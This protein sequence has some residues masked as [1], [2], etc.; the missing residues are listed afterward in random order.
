MKAT[1][2]K[3]PKSQIEISFELTADE[4]KEHFEHALEHLKHHV[5][6]DGFRQGKAPASMV[7]EKLRPEALLMEAGDHAVSHVYHDYIA[8]NKLEPI[9]NPEVKILKIANGSEFAFTAT[10]TILPDVELPDYKEIAKAIKGQEISVTDQEVQDALNYLQKTRAKFTEKSESAENK[11]FVDIIYQSPDFENGKEF[12]DKFILG[13]GGFMKGFEDNIVGMKSG[14]EKEFKVVFGA[15]AP[16]KEL[17]GREMQFKVKL[18]SVKKME[19]PEINDEFAKQMGAFDT[20]VALKENMKEGMVAEKTEAEKQRRRGEI[21]EKI[22]EKS[23]IEIPEAMINY[24]KE[25]LMEDLKNRVAQGMKISFEQY[26]ATTK[27]T[28]DQLKETFQKE[29]EKRLQGYLVLRELGKRENIEVSDKEI[30]EELQK[31]S[32]NYTKEQLAQI[33]INQFKEYT[34]GVL[35]NEKTFQTLES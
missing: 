34:K 4:F 32:K 31:A 2:K 10:I 5:K 9:G 25:N 3:L 23:K 16:K 1:Q 19:L 30:D 20:L 7:Q 24:E 28:E 14:E 8:E 17:A 15:D 22:A 27:Q 35:Y 33:D 6:V 18:V 12:Q 29:A 21:L 13:E 11:D 26:L